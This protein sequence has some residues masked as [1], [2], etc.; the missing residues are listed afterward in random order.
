[1]RGG[2]PPPFATVVAEADGRVSLPA[3]AGL[4]AVKGRADLPRGFTGAAANVTR[5]LICFAFGP[6]LSVARR[7]A[8]NFLRHTLNLLPDSLYFLFGCLPAERCHA[9]SSLSSLLNK[10]CSV[11]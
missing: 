2:L 7:A 10:K 5:H 6:Q 1:V 11:L 9:L 3:A 8:G 4:L